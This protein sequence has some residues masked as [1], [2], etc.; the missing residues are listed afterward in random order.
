MP[1]RFETAKERWEWFLRKSGWQDEPASNGSWEEVDTEL[2]DVEQAVRVQGLVNELGADFQ[3]ILGDGNGVL[4]INAET[5][6]TIFRVVAMA[7][8][9]IEQWPVEPGD[10]LVTS[11]GAKPA[12][13]AKTMVLENLERLEYLA[14]LTL[15][16]GEYRPEGWDDDEPYYP[17]DEDDDDD[18]G[19]W[20]DP[21]ET[22][23]DPRVYQDY[24]NVLNHLIMFISGN[25]WRNVQV[26]YK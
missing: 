5:A 20:R 4:P 25:A 16:E 6:E 8:S 17:D 9:T 2:N 7:T 24:R 10:W 23:S 11:F 18:D 22:S 15:T 12:D 14:N 19:R 1:F 13:Q 26:R 3:P 21:A